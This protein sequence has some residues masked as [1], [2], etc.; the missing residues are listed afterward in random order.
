MSAKTRDDEAYKGYIA[1][2][3]FFRITEFWQCTSQERQYLLGGIDAAALEYYST[4][5]KEMVAPHILEN[6]SHIFGIYAALYDLYPS[7]ERAS[8][9]LRRANSMAPFLG[10]APLTFM[11]RSVGHL[12]LTHRYFR[13]RQVNA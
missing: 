9:G 3:G 11:C 2:K 4:L 13:E 10:E 12:A 5:P 7:L 6:I 1:L 8:R